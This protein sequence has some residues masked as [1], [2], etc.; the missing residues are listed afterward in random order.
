MCTSAAASLAARDSSPFAPPRIEQV[1]LGAY[2][3]RTLAAP[4]IAPR[5]QPPFRASAMDGYALSVE[6]LARRA[7]GPEIGFEIVGEAAA[8]RAWPGTL[9]PAQ[10][11]RIFTGAP[12]PEG[13]DAVVAQ[14]RTRRRE[15]TA[16]SAARVVL[17]PELAVALEAG[18]NIRSIGVDFPA[19][20]ELIAAGTRLH[21]RHGALI[22]AA[23]LGTIAVR[24]RPR[25]ALLANG[26]EL[27]APGEPAGPFEIYDSVTP[28]LAAMIE[29]WGGVPVPAGTAQ[30][31]ETAIDLAVRGA[32]AGADLL[33]I[34][35]GASVGDYDLVK[36]SLASLALTL[37]VESVAVRPG[38]PT[39]F[40]TLP[41]SAAEPSQ[42]AQELPVLGLPGNPAAAFVCAQ[43]FL[44]PLI[45]TLL[46]ASRVPALVTAALEGHLPAVGAEER[47]VRASARVTSDARL[48]VR[49][50]P[51]QDTSL[52]SVY[53]SSNAFIRRPAHEPAAA[54][55]SFVETLLLEIP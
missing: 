13:A 21:A 45:E 55:G 31:S 8:A 20:S 53:A 34:I 2:L 38:K 37:A 43:L 3:H 54:W 39:W 17:E 36:R 47:Y 19:G 4:V 50:D 30:D 11:V 41:V 25:I 44:R 12:V 48:I 26:N 51:R 52:V 23:G 18:A 33:V 10:A 1:P 15:A 49:P 24:R 32:A 40:G 9:G 22:A 46:G 29:E 35:G 28:G 42:A 6:G 7:A 14:E 5:A 16:T 27:R